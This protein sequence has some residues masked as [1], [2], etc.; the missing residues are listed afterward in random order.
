MYVRMY[1][2]CIHAYIYVCMYVRRVRMYVCLL[3]CVYVRMYLLMKPIRLLTEIFKKT[4]TKYSLVINCFKLDFH[5]ARSRG[6]PKV[7]VP[8]ESVP[9]WARPK[10]VEL[11][12]ST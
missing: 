1:E 11:I 3:V 7:G 9:N 6:R 12:F 8:L 4:N 5:P 10:N 2:V